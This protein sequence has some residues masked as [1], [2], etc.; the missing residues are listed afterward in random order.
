MEAAACT[1]GRARPS[2][3]PPRSSSLT[4]QEYRV[5]IAV[6]NGATSREAAASLF[7]SPRTVEYHLAK[8]YR[9]L[10]LRSRSDLVR[11]V[12]ADPEFATDVD[13]PR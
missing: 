13:P 5:A 3:T 2:A 8:I 11:R 6:A 12:A 9:K 1:R 4:P 7:L 10:G